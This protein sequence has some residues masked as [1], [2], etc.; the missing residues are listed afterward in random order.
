MSAPKNNQP[1][2]CQ[3]YQDLM[4]GMTDEDCK[5]FMQM[6]CSSWVRFLNQLLSVSSHQL[7]A[8]DCDTTVA[9][10][11]RGTDT[12]VKG[13]EEIDSIFAET[14]AP[15]IRLPHLGFEDLQDWSNNIILKTASSPLATP[16]ELLCALCNY[17]ELPSSYPAI[18]N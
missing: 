1:S 15:L 5:V 11:E 12:H 3:V 4:A 10:S 7:Q 8:Q 14:E 13:E 18:I 2:L 16:S 9:G 17:K 6:L